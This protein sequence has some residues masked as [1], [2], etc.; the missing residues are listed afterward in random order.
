MPDRVRIPHRATVLSTEPLTPHMV[1]LVFGGEGLRRFPGGDFSDRYVKLQVPEPA[2]GRTRTRTY[3]VR[4]WDEDARRLTIDFVVHGDA[5]IAGPWAS[6]ARPGD[7]LEFFGPGGAYTP[8]PEADWHLLIGD[9]SVI[10]AIGL[11]LARVPAGRPV[12][13]VVEVDDED[14]RQPLETPADLHLSWVYRSADPGEEPELLLEAVRALDLP[15]GRGDAFVHGEATAVRN[16]RRHLLVERG[17]DPAT[18]SAS[19]Y[20][21]HRSEDERWREEKA[22]WRRMAE[23]DVAQTA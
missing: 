12:W 9:A 1:R 4:D 18:L 2:T 23:A 17:L 20:W 7:E 10:P 21:K 8:D 13:V 16:V 5:G 19:G 11:S 3:T 14:E 6:A 15:T 22:E